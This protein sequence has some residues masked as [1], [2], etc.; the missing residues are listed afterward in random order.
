MNRQCVCVCGGG[1]ENNP[2]F[3]K[4]FHFRCLKI[5]FPVL[6]GLQGTSQPRPG[7]GDRGHRGWAWLEGRWPTATSRAEVRCAEQRW[8]LGVAGQGGGW[9]GSLFSKVAGALKYVGP[10]TSSL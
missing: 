6:R 2:D 4:Q 10:L 7:S 5:K 3:Y 9:G 8:R 1:S